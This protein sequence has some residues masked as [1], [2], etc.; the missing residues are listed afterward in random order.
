MSPDYCVCPLHRL[1]G[2][3][4]VKRVDGADLCLTVCHLLSHLADQVLVPCC[5][6]LTTSS[7]SDSQFDS[8]VLHPAEDGYQT[9]DGKV[10]PNRQLI[11]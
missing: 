3:D 6:S 5:G 9:A 11:T 10:C 4:R 8:Y 1:S 2:S 7:F